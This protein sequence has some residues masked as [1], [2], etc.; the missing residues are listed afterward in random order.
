[1]NLIV[2]IGTEKTGTTT[3]QQMLFNNRE[4]F[5]SNGYYFLECVE[6]KNNRKLPSYCM[7]DDKY[8]DYFKDKG[9][10]HLEQKIKFKK[11]F[12]DEFH[13][14]LSSIEDKVH[15]VIVTSEHFSSRLNT[16]VEVRKFYDLVA[17]YFTD[18]RILCYLREQCETAVSLYSTYLRSGFTNEFNNSLKKCRPENSFYNYYKML[19]M[20]SSVFGLDSVEVKIY[21]K[22]NFVGGDL[23]SDFLHAVSPELLDV[24][25]KNVGHHNVSISPFGQG[26]ALSINRLYSVNDHIGMRA[27]K[28]VRKR[29]INCVSSCFPGRGCIP[30]IGEYQEIYNL[31]YESNKMLSN[32]YL[33]IDSELFEFSPPSSKSIFP[34]LEGFSFWGY[35]KFPI[36]YVLSFSSLFVGVKQ[37]IKFLLFHYL[38][39]KLSN[40]YFKKPS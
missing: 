26:I 8:D 3:I 10:L 12:L 30:T 1:M 22:S 39:I 4:I 6:P 14:E 25:D 17:P 15:T 31:F 36:L 21:K 23:I 18:I 33:G 28:T 11:K 40:P 13:E 34:A 37:Y 38:S 35:I 5:K 29:L 7:A 2:H 27:N 24:V 16:H 19:N 32:E 20:W 9:I